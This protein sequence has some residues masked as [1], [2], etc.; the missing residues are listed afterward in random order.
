METQKI[1]CCKQVYPAGMRFPRPRQCSVNASVERDGKWYCGTHDPVKKLAKDIERQKK[2]DLE[3]A[4]RRKE[5]VLKSAAPDL[6]EALEMCVKSMQSVLPDFNQF[7][8]AAFD[9]ARAAIAL[10]RG[11]A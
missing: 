9:K 2:Y 4:R 1:K 3:S 10:A 6:L 8:Q 11:E 7:D 5:W